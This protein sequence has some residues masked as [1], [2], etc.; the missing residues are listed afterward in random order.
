MWT[1]AVAV[2]MRAR[3]PVTSTTGGS[4]VGLEAPAATT[5]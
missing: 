4:P 3:P 2:W 1:T 5:S